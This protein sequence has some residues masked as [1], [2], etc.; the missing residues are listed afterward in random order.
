MSLSVRRLQTQTEII[1]VL[2]WVYENIKNIVKKF[3]EPSDIHFV[4]HAP[5]KNT[6]KCLF[7]K[8]RSF[9]YVPYK[10]RVGTGPKGTGIEFVLS[11]LM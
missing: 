1:A 5:P 11:V 3:S 9:M 10:V 8:R 4:C 7:L 2:Y 6:K